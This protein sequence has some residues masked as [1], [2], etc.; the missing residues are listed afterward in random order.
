MQINRIF[1]A[2]CFSMETVLD[3][4]RP[5]AANGLLTQK[6]EKVAA[7]APKPIY[8]NFYLC[9]HCL[10]CQQL[11]YNCQLI[12]YAFAL[13]MTNVPMHRFLHGG[14]QAQP[15]S[16]HISGTVQA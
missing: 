9:A 16:S 5:V 14:N 7:Y 8:G 15:L 10:M 4:A 6:P 1:A 11:A 12:K 13:C 3:T 2:Q